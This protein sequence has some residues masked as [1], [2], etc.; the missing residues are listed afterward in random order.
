MMVEK[1]TV[2]QFLFRRSKAL[3]NRL[4]I[5][6]TSLLKTLSKLLEI[7]RFNEEGHESLR[8]QR[9]G[10]GGSAVAGGPLNIDVEEQV[11]TLEEFLLNL[12]FE[13]AVTVVVNLGPLIKF[14]RINPSPEFLFREKMVVHAIFF[15]FT[16]RPRRGSDNLPY[17]GSEF[18]N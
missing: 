12:R 14:I 16:R 8:Q 18:L 4:L 11:D 7:L 2:L 5:V 17:L 15:D 9:I 13:S 10:L 1:G 6:Q 3:A